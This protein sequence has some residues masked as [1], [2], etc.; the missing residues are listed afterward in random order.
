MRREA[1]WLNQE[2]PHS[3]GELLAAVNYEWMY[4]ASKTYYKRMLA[5]D[6]T[7]GAKSLR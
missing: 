7:R 2:I 4:Q 6:V 3:P 5:G 1:D